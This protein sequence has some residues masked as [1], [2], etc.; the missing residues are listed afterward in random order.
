MERFVDKKRLLTFDKLRFIY[1]GV[2]LLFFALTETG[3]ELYR[4]YIYS[5]NIKDFGIADTIGNL[6]GTITQI[7]F[8]LFLLYPNYK[9]GKF[10]FPFFIIG[11]SVYECWQLFLPHSNFDYKDII[12]TIIAGIVAYLLYTRIYKIIIKTQSRFNQKFS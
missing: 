7:Y 5:N 12:A 4:P 2:F 1:L 8:M 11:Y 6:F 3:R 9:N 10:F